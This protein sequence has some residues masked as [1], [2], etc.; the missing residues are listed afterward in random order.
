MERHGIFGFEIHPL[1]MNLAKMQHIL[2][3]RVRV[4]YFKVMQSEDSANGFACTFG[5]LKDNLRYL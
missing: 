4:F 1:D 3:Q 5:H 2:L